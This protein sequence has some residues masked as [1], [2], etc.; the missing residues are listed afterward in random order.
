MAEAALD[1]QGDETAVQDT[2]QTQQ[3]PQSTAP[4]TPIAAEAPAAEPAA[5]PVKPT[6]PDDWREILAGEDEKLLNEL[7]RFTS[8]QMLVKS[9]KDT[10]T[11]I[12]S[13]KYKSTLSENPS[14][15]ELAA[16]RQENG[17]PE[18]WEQYDRDLGDGM[19]LGEEDAP[20]VD[21]FLQAMHQ[22]NLPASQAKEVLKWY[23]QWND[24]LQQEQYQKDVEFKESALEELR[25]EW[26]SEFKAN[27]NAIRTVVDGE[28]A[29][30]LF[31]ARAESG[32]RLGDHPAVLK[33]LAQVA[34]E[35]NPAATI[36]P[37]SG[38][39]NLQTVQEE[40][41]EIQSIMREKPYEYWKGPKSAYYQK[42]LQ[43]LNAA[44]ERLQ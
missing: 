42:R 24:N 9:W 35:I 32:E 22:A 14:E 1:L 17:V 29:D 34:R 41:A 33:M 11:K 40:L 28:I 10:R 38:T 15:E 26:G 5:E 3:T 8:P 37:G 13:G 39:N 7:K 2:E 44:A 25:S 4:V 20:I 12:S 27:L 23:Y 6:F 31:N 16:W 19:V 18:S 30:L 21:N 36:I 43:D